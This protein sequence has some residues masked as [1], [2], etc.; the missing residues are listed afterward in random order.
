MSKE[1]V[2]AQHLAD[3]L[4]G[5]LQVLSSAQIHQ[6]MSDW[7]IGRATPKQRFCKTRRM[8]HWPFSNV[9]GG[10][11]L[12]HGLTYG[13]LRTVFFTVIGKAPKIV[14]EQPS[15]PSACQSREQSER[16]ARSLIHHS[17]VDDYGVWTG[18]ASRYLSSRK[19]YLSE[20]FGAAL[21][22]DSIFA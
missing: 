4:S 15:S 18:V 22:A 17:N 8:R 14:L 11:A 20:R 9:I 3:A 12:W 19:R 2:V 6:L 1:I 5:D 10:R 16:Q 21:Q 7:S 13:I